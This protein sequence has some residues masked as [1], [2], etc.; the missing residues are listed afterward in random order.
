MER[1]IIIILITFLLSS[2]TASAVIIDNTQIIQNTKEASYELYLKY[3]EYD[4]ADLLY[5]RSIVSLI[6]QLDEELMTLYIENITALGPR[7]TGTSGIDEAA[8]YIYNQFE[9]MNLSVRYHN[10]TH[11]ALSGKNI[12]GTLKGAD[13]SSDQIF[14]ICG[15]YDNAPE[16]IGANDN[17]AGT[18]SVMSAAKVLSQYEFEHT[19]K[20]ILFSGEEQGLYG[21]L[22]Y[23]MDA[24]KNNDNIV[25]VLNVDMTGY[26]ADKESGNKVTV[27]HNFRSKW[28]PEKMIEISNIYNN[29][30]NL[31]VEPKRW[32]V[33]ESD[34]FGFWQNNFDAVE[35]QERTINP[36]FHTPE[37]NMSNVNITYATKVAKLTLATLADLSQITSPIIGKTIH[38][39]GLEENN[40]TKIQNAIENSTNGDTIIIHSETFDEQITIT[41]SIDLIAK[42]DHESIITSEKKGAV[43]KIHADYSYISGLTIK[44]NDKFWDS[45]AIDIYSDNCAILRNNITDNRGYGIGLKSA[46]HNK[47]VYNNINNNSNGIMLWGNSIYNKIY[48]NNIT[49]NEESG[50]TLSARSYYT[51]IRYNKINNNFY[52]IYTQ[53]G[54]VEDLFV[55]PGENNFYNNIITNNSYGI[56]L[57]LYSTKN[58]FISNEISNNNVGIYLGPGSRFNRIIENNFLEND[59][60]ATFESVIINIWRRN[61][62]DNRT[63]NF[64]PKIIKGIYRDLPFITMIPLLNFD[65]I[66]AFKPYEIEI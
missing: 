66:P 23:A 55:N 21:S 54:R 16:T 50:I 39:G 49:N 9:D 40:Y 59:K 60:H 27:V 19:I 41:K 48:Y 62:W 56:Y 5:G 11:D 45:R 34:H 53:V 15:H 61:Y 12:E 6:D 10:W 1:K 2:Y 24:A 3:D 64:G 65:F 42:I 17:G 38:V 52:G 37:D 35:I 29:Y 26:A 22:Y 31:E 8:E 57:N 47:L 13:Q 25:A 58:K 18:V 28:I 7:F 44:N 32:F 14:I 43:V 36:V 51:C 46:S 33:P 20:F 63:I 4:R 30:I